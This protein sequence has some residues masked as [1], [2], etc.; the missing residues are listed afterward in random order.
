[1]TVFSACFTMSNT[2][3]PSLFGTPSDSTASDPIDPSAID[4]DFEASGDMVLESM[5]YT[6]EDTAGATAEGVIQ[7]VVVSLNDSP[8]LS[9]PPVFIYDDGHG[10]AGDLGASVAF[11][12]TAADPDDNVEVHGCKHITWIIRNDD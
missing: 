12:V 5:R 1:M 7:S 9:I 3:R 6:A 2:L 8:S 11:S 10:S 4:P